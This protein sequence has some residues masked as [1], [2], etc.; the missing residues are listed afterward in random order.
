MHYIVLAARSYN[1][2]DEKDATRQ[3][4]GLTVH[5]LDPSAV[6]DTD[7][8]RMG[9]FPLQV[10]APLTLLPAF[11]DPGH[12]A[13]TAAG[14]VAHAPEGG[15]IT[16]PPP[17]LLPAVYDLTFAQRPGKGNR[18]VLTCIGAKPVARVDI[19]KILKNASAKA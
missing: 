7:P 18:P 14:P 13:I 4:E 19:E 8:S 3:V 11:V 2:Q 12:R 6:D 9:M 10:P 15:G 1:F 16:P 17:S 5:Y